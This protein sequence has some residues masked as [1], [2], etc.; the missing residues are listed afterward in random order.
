M[1][2]CPWCG[3]REF[4][5]DIVHRYGGDPVGG[6][7]GPDAWAVALRC[8]SCSATT[9]WRKG[10]TKD[11]AEARAQSCAL[12]FQER[13]ELA[14]TDWTLAYA[15]GESEGHSRG[16]LAAAAILEVRA[17][18]LAKSAKATETHGDKALS[19]SRAA[20]SSILKSLARDIFRLL[21]WRPEEEIFPTKH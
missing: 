20:M 11:E 9:P 13:A 12:A 1:I 15:R 10:D 21:P 17:T 5:T 18:E 2:V 16:L 4:S 14:R 19:R 8:N 3:F 6:E 7:N